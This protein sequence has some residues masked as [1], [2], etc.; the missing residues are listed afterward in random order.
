MRANG[1]LIDA[2]Y[3]DLRVNREQAL[4]VW[5]STIPMQPVVLGFDGDGVR[6][7]MREAAQAVFDSSRGNVSYGWV[8]TAIDDPEVRLAYCA[9]HICTNVRVIGV[10]PP[11]ASE[12]ILD[13]APF[14]AG[15]TFSDGGNTFTRQGSL[16]PT[17]TGISVTEKNLNVAIQKLKE[18]RA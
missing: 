8:I 1:Q 15:G 6:F 3:A 16:H 17:Y 9:S 4:S 13:P 5:P 7:S 2:P 14:L 12:G 18:K 11:S 10:V